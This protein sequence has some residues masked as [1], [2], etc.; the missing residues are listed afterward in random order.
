MIRGSRF[1]TITACPKI[2][3]RHARIARLFAAQGAAT[4]SFDQYFVTTIDELRKVIKDLPE[5]MKVEIAEGVS[6]TATTV[7]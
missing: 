5:E 7:P 6:I 2:G 3:Q 4:M 1:M